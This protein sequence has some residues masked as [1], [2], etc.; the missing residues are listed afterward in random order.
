VVVAL[1]D[2]AP[3]G[4]LERAG[5]CHC[6]QLGGHGF[7]VHRVSIIARALAGASVGVMATIESLDTWGVLH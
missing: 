5:F 6:P 2:P 4:E 3:D 1:F 7:D